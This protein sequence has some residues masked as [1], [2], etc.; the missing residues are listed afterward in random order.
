[1]W[2]WL[3][4]KDNRERI[5][6]VSTGGA[7][8]AAGLWTVF[9]YIAPDKK[10]ETAAPT[11]VVAACG[12]AAGSSIGAASITVSCGPSEIEIKAIVAKV[13]SAADLAGL[14]ERAAEHESATTPQTAELASK[15]GLPPDEVSG[16]FKALARQGLDANRATAQ[17]ATVARDYLDVR[18]RQDRLPPKDP[19]TLYLRQQAAAALRDGDIDHARLLVAAAQLVSPQASAVPG[20]T[21]RPVAGDPRLAGN[22]KLN[23]AYDPHGF[24]RTD[25]MQLVGYQFW[26]NVTERIPLG[27]VGHFSN[28]P[29]AE[30]AT[31]LHGSRSFF[32]YDVSYAKAGLA[33]LPRDQA[34]VAHYT[35]RIRH[36]GGSIVWQCANAECGAEE[37]TLSQACL[38]VAN[39]YY[40]DE[41]RDVITRT[42]ALNTPINGFRD[43]PSECHLMVGIVPPN[44]PQPAFYISIF[45]LDDP[46]SYYDQVSVILDIV[47]VSG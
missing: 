16:I 38:A 21:A 6:F 5:A 19:E 23:E 15:L 9:V 35:D 32:I 40:P 17:F 13:V 41:V 22:T 20:L 24:L 4:K 44:G 1:M 2:R 27:P 34:V 37:Q 18:D 46:S 26:P 10:A 47:A 8:V 43:K 25:E 11:S 45:M 14:V 12:V 36:A 29:V 31:E 28:N 42:S 7:A 3:S 39:W 33:H 30:R